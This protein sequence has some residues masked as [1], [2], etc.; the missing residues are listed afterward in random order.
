M[1]QEQ[2][3]AYIRTNTD[4][5]RLNRLTVKRCITPSAGGSGTSVSAEGIGLPSPIHSQ[6]QVKVETALKLANEL[7]ERS[8]LF[9]RTGGVHN[10]ALAKGEEIL[11]FQEDIGR[12]NT[13][14]KIHG[15]C[16]LEGISRDDKV[17]IFSGRVSSEIVLKVARM[18]VPILISSICTHRSRLTAGREDEHYCA[19]FCTGKKA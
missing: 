6:L 4:F 5:S 14:D 10:A 13:L 3:A 8:H 19:G 16:F 12:H 15:Q 7:Q 2:G 11:I 18:R 9:Q 17:V 1:D